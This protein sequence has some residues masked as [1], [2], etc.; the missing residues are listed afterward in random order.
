MNTRLNHENEERAESGEIDT[1]QTLDAV[2]IQIKM[3]LLNLK[4]KAEDWHRR[5]RKEI[6]NFN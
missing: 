3:A 6:S 4:G 1:T 5:K 2:F